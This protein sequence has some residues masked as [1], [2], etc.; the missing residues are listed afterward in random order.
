MK[1]R[2]IFSTLMFSAIFFII[3]CNKTGTEQIINPSEQNTVFV[4]GFA[5]GECGGNCAHFVKIDSGKV[6]IDDMVYY[7]GDSNLKFLTQPLI[8][9]KYNL[10][11]KVLDSLPAFFN[12]MPDSTF[13]CPDCHDQ[14]GYHVSLTRNNIKRSWHLDPDFTYSKPDLNRFTYLIKQ[15]I[16]SIE[17]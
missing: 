16:D 10:A 9:S 15:T 17:K 12:N 2:I 6:Y 11:K 3:S 4:F 14:G 13:G 7:S 5:Y 1:T 8:Q